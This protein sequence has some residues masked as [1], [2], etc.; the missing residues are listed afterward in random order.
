MR[1]KIASNRRMNIPS[2]PK[3]LVDPLLQNIDPAALV[4]AK[5]P[6]TTR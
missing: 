6:L 4:W 2:D 1:L 3:H 5:T